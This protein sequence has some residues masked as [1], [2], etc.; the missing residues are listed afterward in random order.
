MERLA[1]QARGN[2]VRGHRVLALVL[3]SVLFAGCAKYNTYYNAKRSF[4]RAEDVRDEALKKHQDPPK[5]GG[6]Q[7]NDYEQAIKKAQKV[8]DEYPGHNLTDDA[9][10]LQAKAH[11]R[12]ESYRQ[13]IRKLDLLFLNYPAT[14]YMEEALY[15]QGLNYLLIGALDNSQKFLERLSTK[16]PESDFLAETRKVS[17]DNAY[18]LKDWESAAKSYREYLDLDESVAERDRVGLK[19]AKC[20]W[21]MEDY[22]P[23]AEILQEVG[24]TTTSAELAF[25]SRLLRARVH[26]HMNDFS[27]VD[28]LVTALRKEAEIYKS[29]GEVSLVEAEALVA[30]GRQDEAAPLLENL[31]AEW[32]NADVKARAAEILG[33]IYLERGEWEQA[34]EQYQAA[35]LKK[36]V[37]NDVDQARQLSENLGDYLAAERAL[38]DAQGPR[39]ASL[40]LLQ[41]NSLLFGFERPHMA[42]TLY[43]EAGLDTTAADA[44]A[45]R[46]LYGAY[47]SYGSYLDQPDSATTFQNLLL[48]KFPK[49][50]Q[51]HEVSSAT[52]T[53][54][55]GYLMAMRTAEQRENYAD[56]SAEEL[57]ALVNPEL[58]VTAQTTTESGLLGVRRRLV[59]LSR[60]D[61]IIFPPAPAAVQKI[62]ARR[63]LR[64]QEAARVAAQQAEFDSLLVRDQ[65]ETL[66]VPPVVPVSEIGEV[67]TA[68]AD[69][70]SVLATPTAAADK[71]AEKKKKKQKK[72]DE[73]W[74]FLR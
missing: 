58:A 29:D 3:I 25:R 26:A 10:F 16:Y 5:P 22:Y 6:A 61:N 44:V 38:A 41:A 60:R 70:V 21:E 52:D 40:K 46:A 19:L 49:S 69:S 37:L 71:P 55:L 59:Y 74:D 36:T 14:P 2:G 33:R 7:R 45:A 72:Q 47:V 31:P 56:L 50:P 24:Q 51:A 67:G 43:A 17:G 18:V 62:V 35:L 13:S 32:K 73:D 64:R 20:Y 65:G 53:D 23:A 48:E 54:L 57:A 9:L 11:H 1:R 27:L 4:D 28:E 30:Q 66:A 68:P 39:V 8:L 12:L 34:R 15:L 63:H 42:A